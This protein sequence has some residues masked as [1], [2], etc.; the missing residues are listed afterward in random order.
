VT[1]S[2]SARLVDLTGRVALV[3]GVARGLG[4]AAVLRLHELGARD[5]ADLFAFV[6]SD[7]AGYIPGVSF[8]I[9]GGDLMM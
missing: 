5:V 2:P 3:T 6:A 4:Q 7:A 1:E 8:D 9:T